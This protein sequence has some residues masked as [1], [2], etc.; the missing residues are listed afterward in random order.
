MSAPDEHWLLV[1]NLWL[2]IEKGLDLLGANGEDAREKIDSLAEKLDS[3]LI[4]Q[5]HYLR[6]ERN[7]L[8]HKNKALSDSSRWET[9][10]KRVTA[11]IQKKPKSIQEKPNKSSDTKL[12]AVTPLSQGYWDAV[13]ILFFVDLAIAIW[14]YEEM[15]GIMGAI[16]AVLVF[17]VST[18][19]ASFISLLLGA[20]MDILRSGR[21]ND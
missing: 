21:C 3:A 2:P 6:M 7:A 20:F 11:S 15:Q 8:I 16:T 9:T 19:I 4:D 13:W 12:N 5:L 10:A 14:V 17:F 1:K 18:F